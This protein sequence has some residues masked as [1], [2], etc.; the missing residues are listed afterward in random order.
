MTLKLLSL[1][2]LSIWLSTWSVWS[3]SC[4]DVVFV[5]NVIDFVDVFIVSELLELNIVV[6][7]VIRVE[8]DDNVRQRM[9]ITLIN[10]SLWK[11]K[12]ETLIIVVM[13]DVAQFLFDL[14]EKAFDQLINQIDAVCHSIV[15]ID[16]MWSLK[17]YIKFN[18]QSMQEI[19]RLIFIDRDKA[20]HLISTIV[21]LSRYLEYDVSENENEYDYFISKWMS[22]QMMIIAR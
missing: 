12:F 7:D 8:F 15:L 3:V 17:D 9:M 5:T 20:I 18:V 2:I 1:L 4:L 22:E 11:L 16:W 6:Y 19:L 14:T 21:V 10:Y 13:N